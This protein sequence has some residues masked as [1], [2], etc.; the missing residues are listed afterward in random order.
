MGVNQSKWSL[1]YNER[2]SIKLHPNLGE[3]FYNSFDSAPGLSRS[4]WRGAM[5]MVAGVVWPTVTSGARGQRLPQ[6]GNFNIL[7]LSSVFDS[8][9]GVLFLLLHIF[10]S[11]ILIKNN[12]LKEIRI[13]S[14]WE[15]NIN[16]FGAILLCFPSLYNPFKYMISLIVTTTLTCILLMQ[17][18][19]TCLSA[20]GLG[21]EASLDVSG[22]R[23]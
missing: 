19:I 22:C 20:Y 12:R 15:K 2:S 18:L 5:F 23:G 9:P 4:A 7:E 11:E 3:K 1:L 6:S 17:S 14:L 10:N 16:T 13:V 21:Q 8:F